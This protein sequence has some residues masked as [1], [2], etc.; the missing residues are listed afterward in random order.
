MTAS[1]KYGKDFQVLVLRQLRRKAKNSV[2]GM[3]SS[4]FVPE[5]CF[6]YSMSKHICFNTENHLPE[7]IY[8]HA[9]TINITYA[10]LIII[11]Q[12]RALRNRSPGT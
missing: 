5:G 7:M 2:Q 1:Q 8:F 3:N 11:I 12:K 4:P 6:S 10:T 9:N